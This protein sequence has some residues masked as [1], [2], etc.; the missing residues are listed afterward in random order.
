MALNNSH[1]V[2]SNCFKD[3]LLWFQGPEA[4]ADDGQY[5]EM[6][7]HRAESVYNSGINDDNL[8]P[9]WRNPLEN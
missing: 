8:C 9:K 3:S 1:N 7:L 5:D 4:L 2:T 6:L